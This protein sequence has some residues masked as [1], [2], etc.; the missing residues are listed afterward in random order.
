MAACAGV[1]RHPCQGE[2]ND[3]QTGHLLQRG[4]TL[5]G[6]LYLPDDLASGEKRAGIVLC[7]GYTGVR[8]IYLPDNARALTEAGY[9]VLNFDYKGWGDSEGPKTRLAP[10]S[11][12]ADVQAALTFLA[13]Q[14]EVAADRLGADRFDAAKLVFAGCAAAPIEIDIAVLAVPNVPKQD[15]LAG[16]VVRGLGERAWARNG[17]A[18]IVEP[19]SRDVPAGNLGQDLRSWIR[20]RGLS[21]TTDA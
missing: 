11:R 18:A 3:A 19:V 1:Q 20:P 7:H 15:R 4:V 16:A 13:A 10:Y 2:E 8:N 12:I 21:P 6:D 9:V 17:A 14:P 5:A